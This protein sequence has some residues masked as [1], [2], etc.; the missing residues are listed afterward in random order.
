MNNIIIASQS[1]SGAVSVC[2]SSIPYDHST[3]VSPQ[4]I[5]PLFVKY[6][7]IVE[8]IDDK[9]LSNCGKILGKISQH[10][11]NIE[12]LQDVEKYASPSYFKFR[13]S[14]LPKIT[15]EVYLNRLSQYC[16]FSNGVLIIAMR[17]I[18]RILQKLHVEFPINS[19]VIYRLVLVD[20]MV[21]AKFLDDSF[22]SNLI[23]SKVGGISLKE[24]NELEVEFLDLIC[25]DLFIS[26]EDFNATKL[27]IVPEKAAH[28]NKQIKNEE[29]Q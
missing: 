16:D 23:Y 15:I 18:F 1:S 21:T 25:C 12:K 7:M 5:D 8:V 27:A 9:L 24:I 22:A 4:E 3:N 19:L 26:S 20:I 29:T 11:N 13:S 6:S 2:S 10:N 28:I 17:N 14:E